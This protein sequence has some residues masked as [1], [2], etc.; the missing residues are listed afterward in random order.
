MG[1][2]YFHDGTRAA[3]AL[4]LR[5]VRNRERVER[6]RTAR[7]Y[8]VCDGLPGGG[9]PDALL[10][11]AL[12]GGADII[13][14]REKS[15]RCA[16]ELI[17][18]AEPFRRAADAHGALFILNDRPDLVAECGA[19]GVHVGQDDA[20]VAEAREAAGPGALV[21]LSTHSPG[22]ID[23]A[24]DAEGAARPDQISVGP[25]W[26][27]PTKAGRPAT[28]LELVSLRGEPRHPALVR[29]R[30][31][32][33]R[34]RRRGGR[35]RR[36]AR[37]RGAGD[38]RRRRPGGRGARL[39]RLPRREGDRLMADSERKRAERRKR[40]E[41]GVHR[42]QEL[43]ERRERM[44][45]KTEAKNEAAREALEPLEED[46]RPRVVTI[47]AVISAV[48]CASIVIGYFAGVEIDGER[49][50][51]VQVLAPL[52][53]FG[54]MAWGLW[55]S[56][57]WAVLGFQT[58]L[59]FAIVGASLSLVLASQWTQAVGNVLL[60]G[61]SGALFFFNIKAMARIQMPDRS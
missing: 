19:D 30:R 31:H 29:D 2:R 16:E 48:V 22:Q 8:F 46:E 24:C 42:Q 13:Q 51:I 9:P 33:R 34:Q 58:V 1:S 26:E 50:N 11:A 43:A 54:V 56:R 47:G 4:S 59:L 6:L 35:G 37:R 49:P 44:A 18:L 3:S 28:G 27:T 32:R 55:E 25:V 12:R 17:A 5:P 61:G 41:R 39:A 21:G 15:P 57:Y 23:A 52:I 36:A 40:K 20:P 45:A 14:L 38:P 53:I 10:D 60:I 7:L